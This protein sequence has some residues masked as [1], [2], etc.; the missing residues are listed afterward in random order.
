MS[1]SRY[2]SRALPTFTRLALTSALVASGLALAPALTPLEPGLVS[3]QAVAAEKSAS[4]QAYVSSVLNEDGTVTVSGSGWTSEAEGRGAVVSFKWEGGG[5]TNKEAPINPVTDE[6]N[7]RVNFMTVAKKDGTFSI[8]VEL[9]TSETTNVKDEDWKPGSQHK[10]QVLSGSAGE[11]DSVGTV[12]VSFTVPTIHADNPDTWPLVEAEGAQVRISPVTTG[13]GASIR[14]IGQG[15]TRQDGGGSTVSLKLEYLDGEQKVRQ[16]E[17]TDSAI[18]D[19]LQSVGRAADPTSWGLL[20]PDSSKTEPD[21]GLLPIEEDGSF[22]V[23]LELP[24]GVQEGQIGDYLALFVQSGRNADRDVSRSVRS[25]PI[26]VDGV[27]GELPKTDADATVCSTDVG[28]PTFRIVNPR[29]ELGGKLHVTG[30]G[31]CNTE[32]TKATTVAIKIDDG[33]VSHLDSSLHSNRTIW[34]IIKPDPTTGVIDAYIDLPDG[35]TATSTPAFEEGAHSLRVL[36]GSLSPGDR[37]VTLGGKDTLSFVVGTY[38]PKE[39]P[40]TLG[41]DDLTDEARNGVTVEKDQLQIRATV[42]GANPGQWVILNPYTGGSVRSNWGSGWVQ[43]DENRSLTYSLPEELAAGDYQMV[44]QNGDE[45]KLGELLGWAPLTVATDDAGE[46]RQ[47]DNRGGNSSGQ[48]GTSGSSNRSSGSG[49]STGSGA[50]TGAGSGSSSIQPPYT[51]TTGNPMQNRPVAQVATI[52][53]VLRAPAAKKVS[54]TEKATKQEEKKAAS[55]SPSS[56]ASQAVAPA[57]SQT[58]SYEASSETEPPWGNANNWLLCA[59][60]VVLLGALALTRKSPKK[61]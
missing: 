42:P 45:G 23:T 8:N 58:R 39:V 61:H 53:Q 7:D 54:A 17:R 4:K 10:L 51:S 35:T 47:P 25:E 40:D 22:D 60:A 20:I 44:V 57:E 37:A 18:S 3:S 56:S 41:A 32:N 31:W 34:A 30:E 12:A 19:Y 43:L 36:S 28:S 16:Y 9:P 59:A 24:E 55:P 33:G 5:V 50:S 52:S 27:P 15:W 6:P 2:T 11:G 49:S 26:P 29:V 46:R 38:A 14:F 48:Q 21:Q 13:E 1:S